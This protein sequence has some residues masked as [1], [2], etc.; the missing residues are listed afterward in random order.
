MNNPLTDLATILTNAGYTNVYVDFLPEIPQR[1]VIQSQPSGEFTTPVREVDFVI[2]V[3]DLLPSDASDTA[4][5]LAKLLYAYNGKLTGTDTVRVMQTKIT[6]APYFWGYNSD[7]KATEYM[8]SGTL[9]IQ[10]Q[11]RTR[12]A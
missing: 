8:F 6:N 1:I 9:L 7:L 2:Y 4:D 5:T 3:R 12:I 11:D 10:D